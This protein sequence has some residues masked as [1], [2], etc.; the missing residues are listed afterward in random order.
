MRAPPWAMLLLFLVTYLQAVGSLPSA[1][2]LWS[3]SPTT[4]A[5]LNATALGWVAVP[6]LALALTLEPLRAGAPP[7]QP[8][9]VQYTVGV[10]PDRPALPGGNFLSDAGGAGVDAG[11]R[12]YV[13]ARLVVDGAPLRGTGSSLSLAG[14]SD[15][16]GG[17]LR[18]LAAVPLAAGNHTLGVQWRMWG[19][20]ARGWRCAPGRGRSGHSR[21]CRHRRG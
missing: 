4:D 15:G 8:L 2:P 21:P 12:D 17:L 13:A 9:L 18:G 7:R 10:S 16:G 5:A 6:G 14:A 1:A 20:A 19:G 3:V 11:S